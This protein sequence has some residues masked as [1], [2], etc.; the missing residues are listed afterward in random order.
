MCCL[1]V[2]ATTG[3]GRLPKTIT[4]KA[5]PFAEISWRIFKGL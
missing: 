2:E 3:A 5:K 1:Q 4:A